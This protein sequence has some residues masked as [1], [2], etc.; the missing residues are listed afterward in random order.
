MKS[1]NAYDLYVELLAGRYKGL[2]AVFTGDFDDLKSRD[3]QNEG[4]VL[5]NNFHSKKPIVFKSF[6]AKVI[7]FKFCSLLEVSFIGELSAETII[8]ERCEL[9]GG[10]NFECNM[11]N[12]STIDLRFIRGQSSIVFY[13]GYAEKIRLGSL[14]GQLKLNVGYNMKS[15]LIDFGKALGSGISTHLEEIVLDI[16][17][18]DE[19]NLYG[20]RA[21]NVKLNGTNND[22]QVTLRNTRIDT[23]YLNSFLPKDFKF[24]HRTNNVLNKLI[25]RDVNL[26][27]FRSSLNGL[28]RGLNSIEIQEEV[29]VSNFDKFIEWPEEVKGSPKNTQRFFRDVKEQCHKTGDYR[30]EAIFKAMEL[31]AYYLWS[32]NEVKGISDW[33]DFIFKVGLPKWVSNFGQSLSKPM[34][35]LLGTHLFLVVLMISVSGSNLEIG[36]QG[37][38]WL[39]SIWE[40]MKLYAYTILPTHRLSYMNSDLDPVISL[41]MRLVSSICIYHIVLASRKH[42]EPK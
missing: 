35:W 3:N 16:S 28:F 10:L 30:R 6:N 2:Q 38:S 24:F 42:L 34:I 12:N 13:G 17:K 32:K 14:E 23:L 4:T 11:P 26:E 21:S 5:F 37:N 15:E 39:S 41:L 25:L 33:F 7:H 18:L 27:Y 29:N 1:V 22:S 40:G 19:V 36:W 9:N 8:F 31:E 20:I